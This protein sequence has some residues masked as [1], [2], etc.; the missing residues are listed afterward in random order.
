MIS[1]KAVKWKKKMHMLQFFI[2]FPST[3]QLV[4]C[5]W[6]SAP[7]Q[8]DNDPIHRNNKISIWDRYLCRKRLFFFLD[9]QTQKDGLSALFVKSGSSYLVVACKY[10]WA[11]GAGRLSWEEQ[12]VVQMSDLH[13]RVLGWRRHACVWFV[14]IKK[15]FN[16]FSR[17][18]CK[19]KWWKQS[20][21]KCT[22]HFLRSILKPASA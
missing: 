18:T 10:C 3:N 21:S 15:C 19:C 2:P 20:R 5:I 11:R 1:R 9:W 22:M 8:T 12:I 6:K 16:R 7:K 17:S 13:G 14:K 4:G